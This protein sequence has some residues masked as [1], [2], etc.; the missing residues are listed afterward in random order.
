MPKTEYRI[1]MSIEGSQAS[2]AKLTFRIDTDLA[3]TPQALQALRM[4]AGMFT[5]Q[6]GTVITRWGTEKDAFADVL[7]I[8]KGKK[9]KG[10]TEA[11]DPI[12]QIERDSNG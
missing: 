8:V 5:Q 7:K 9:I 1:D 12:D 2:D 11:Y 10:V 6:V 3:L 4:L